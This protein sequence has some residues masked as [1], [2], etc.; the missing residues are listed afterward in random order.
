MT[1]SMPVSPPT[2][3][4]KVFGSLSKN[5]LKANFVIH[6]ASI[7]NGAMSNQLESMLFLVSFLGPLGTVEGTEI[8]E[9]VWI[10]GNIM[11]TM[12]NPS[13]AKIKYIFDETI[14][15]KEGWYFRQLPSGDVPPTSQMQNQIPNNHLML[16]QGFVNQIAVMSQEQWHMNTENQ[17]NEIA[18]FNRMTMTQP[19]DGYS[20]DMP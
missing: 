18:H 11:A 9:A 7:I 10:E 20:Q 2:G 16:Q 14:N 19:W 17:D 6:Q 5:L 8:G 4:G 12:A 15:H 13:N 1:T 3:K